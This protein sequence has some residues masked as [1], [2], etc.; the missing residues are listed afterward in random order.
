[1]KIADEDKKGFEEKGSESVRL[2]PERQL[3][4]G[5]QGLPGKENNIERGGHDRINKLDTH[6]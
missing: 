2:E 3:D 5:K 4:S 6:K 1:M